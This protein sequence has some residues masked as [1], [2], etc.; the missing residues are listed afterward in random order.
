M[1]QHLEVGLREELCFKESAHMA[2][3]NAPVSHKN[4]YAV[5]FRP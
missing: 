5:N 3:R 4:T 2:F 1:N